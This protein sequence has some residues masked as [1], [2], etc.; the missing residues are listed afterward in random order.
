M[1]TDALEQVLRTTERVK[2][3]Y[4]VPD[5]QNPTGRTLSLERRR[6]LIELAGSSTSSSSRTRPIA[7]CATRESG[8]VAQEPRHDGPRRPPRQLSKILAPAC[9]SVGLW[10]RQRRWRSCPSSLAADTQN[11]TLN[12]RAAA[13]YLA[14]F[15]IERHIASMLPTYRASA[16]SCS[17]PSRSISLK[18]SPGPVRKGV[19]SPG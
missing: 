14:G 17:R 7:S 9:G 3:I 18:E 19:S 2:L 1:D 13:A 10:P 5:F 12:M 6:R 8:A 11:G 16:T 4:T 15:D